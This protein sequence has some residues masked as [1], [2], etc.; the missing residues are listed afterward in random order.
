MFTHI[1]LFAGIGGF[2][3]PL[4]SAIVKEIKKQLL[5]DQ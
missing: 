5:E 3:I 4:V 2:T 1:D